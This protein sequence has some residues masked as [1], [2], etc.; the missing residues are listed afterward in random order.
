MEPSDNRD[1]HRAGA[2][3]DCRSHEKPDVRRS[4]SRRRETSPFAL[5]E[6]GPVVKS[7]VSF[8]TPHR[9]SPGERCRVKRPSKFAWVDIAARGA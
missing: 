1:E 5:Y 6:G 3:A 2:N 4:A 7:R 9:Y 8:L